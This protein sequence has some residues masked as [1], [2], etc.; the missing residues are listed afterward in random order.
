MQ[1]LEAF[2][3]TLGD[4]G[5]DLR[6]NLQSV[7]EGASVLD[8]KQRWGVAVAC[9]ATLRQPELSRA[10]VADARAAVGEDVVD[11][12]LAA[13]A[14]MGMNNAFYRFRHLVE[15][16][17]YSSKSPRLRMNRIAQV[18]G[19]KVDF[20]LFSLAASSLGACAACVQAHERA[21]I[22]AGLSEDHVLDAVRIA[23]V[24][25]GVAIAYDATLASRLDAT[26][27]MEQA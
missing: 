24:L 11:D 25:R 15:K 3:T 5:K 23:A 10:V 9:A 18:R 13:A 27:A 8:L 14:V 16:E 4:F 19:A 21:V 2:R 7:L 17:S 20:E 26:Q 6:L 22:D 1:A 12:G